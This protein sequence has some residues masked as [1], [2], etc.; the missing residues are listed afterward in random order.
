M[1]GHSKWATTKHKKAKVDNAR[2]KMFTKLS[3]EIMVAAKLGGDNPE[4]NFRLRIAIEKAKVGNMPADN[5]KK[6][7]Q[8]GAGGMDG[9]SYEEMVYEGYGP[10]GT[11]LIMEL[12]TNNRNRTAGEIRHILDKNGGNLGETGCVGW[13]F[14]KL[15]YISVEKEQILMDEDSFTLFSIENGAED[16]K[17]QDNH[18]EVLTAIENLEPLRKA[19]AQEKIDIKEYSIVMIPKNTVSVTDLEQAK[20]IIKL[21]EMLEDHDDVQNLYANIEIPDEILEAIE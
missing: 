15:G 10:F 8:K 11:A 20:K 16:L 7:V 5:I 12:M 17:V 14:D 21:L 9:E 19:L 13:M 18:Y 1:A 6:A 4:N 2:G 3:K